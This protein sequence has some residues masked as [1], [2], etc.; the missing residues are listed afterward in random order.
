MHR[1]SLGAIGSDCG[2]V[3]C[4]WLHSLLSL[5]TIWPLTVA[6][7][8]GLNRVR[9]FGAIGAYQVMSSR[10]QVCLMLPV[11]SLRMPQALCAHSRHIRQHVEPYTGILARCGAWLEGAESLVV[12]SCVASGRVHVRVYARRMGEE[13]CACLGLS[14]WGI[15]SKQSAWVL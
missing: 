11:C 10:L 15:W 3:D 2:C 7:R 9:G 6:E 1:R 4:G 14:S 5:R 8:Q 12:V 13:A